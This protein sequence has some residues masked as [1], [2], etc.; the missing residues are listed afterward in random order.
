MCVCVCGGVGGGGGRSIITHK[1]LFTLLAHH[2]EKKLAMETHHKNLLDVALFHTH[3]L[4]LAGT[5]RAH[6]VELT[7]GVWTGRIVTSIVH[8]L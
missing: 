8:V 3:S 5:K 6:C 2:G 1:E 7:V 4:M